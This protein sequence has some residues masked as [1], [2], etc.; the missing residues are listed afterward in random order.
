M[1]SGLEYLQNGCKPPIFHRDVK[2]T[3]ILLNEQL[4]AKLSD[5]GLSKIILTDG[6]THVSTVIAGTP[7]Y[8]D[9]EWVHQLYCPVPVHYFPEKYSN[10]IWMFMFKN[11]WRK[12]T[13][14]TFCLTDT[15]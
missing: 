8:L 5:F 7:G 15:T 6:G 11:F 3:N 14:V 9:P 10:S 13:R 2:S 4:Q 12:I 1:A